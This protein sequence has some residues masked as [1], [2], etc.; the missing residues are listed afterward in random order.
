LLIALLP[1]TSLFQHE[2]VKFHWD[3]KIGYAQEIFGNI[4]Q[5]FTSNTTDS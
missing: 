2:L 5:S 1:S 3:S 4:T